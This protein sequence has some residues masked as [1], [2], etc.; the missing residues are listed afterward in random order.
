MTQIVVTGLGA[1]TPVGNDVPSSWNALLE[2][3]SGVGR[4]TLFDATSFEPN[5]GAEVKG[6][7]PEAFLPAREV[8]RMDRYSQLGTV[9]ALEA[10]ADAGLS[11]AGGLGESVGVVMGAGSGGYT[12]LGEQYHILEEKGARRVS[13]FFLTNV[14]PDAVSGHIA[15]LTGAM[16][17]NMAVISACA[18]GA[19]AIGEAAEIIRRGDA[20]VMIAG[21][22]EASLNPILY[23]SFVALRA[24]APPGDDPTTACK[25]FDRRRQGFIVGEGAA[26]VVLETLEHA[27]ARGA[28]VYGE[29]A[30]Y[31]ASNDA[32]DMAAAEPSGRGPVL[33]I[34]MALRKAGLAP[35]SVGY[36]NA[37]GTGTPM[38]DRTETVALKRVF[39]EH[40]YRFAVSSTKSMTG[41]LMGAAG[42]FEAVV[43]LLALRDQV[44]PPTINYKD[45]DPECDLDYVPNVARPVSG[46]DV[47]LSTSIGL[48][49]HNAA[50]LFRRV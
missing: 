7:D 8:R 37:H 19:S 39:G 1:V 42:A 47:A 4:I 35:E 44:L 22:A 21:G 41:H 34:N 28:T 43:T 16:G 48:G 2:G 30:G 18:T 13:P 40:A 29:L 14:I 31:G 3:R 45:P 33:A 6:F 46:L 17:P 9:A 10:V 5:I 20:E 24:I 50:L 32:F 36:V 27:Q 38:N 11:T 25:P 49:G 15:I 12:L 26:A 23:A